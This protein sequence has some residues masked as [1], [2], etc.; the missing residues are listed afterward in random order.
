MRGLLS[1][2]FREDG[3]CAWAYRGFEIRGLRRFGV[4]CGRRAG[5]TG[6]VVFATEPSTARAAGRPAFTAGVACAPRHPAGLTPLPGSPPPHPPQVWPS[7]HRQHRGVAHRPLAPAGQDAAPA[8]GLLR[9]AAHGC[10]AA[11]ARFA[12][13][14]S[15]FCTT[16]LTSGWGGVDKTAWPSP[17]DR[18]PRR[19]PD[20]PP[21]TPLAT[22]LPLN[23]P[24]PHPLHSKA[25]QQPPTPPQTGRL[26]NRFTK[27][28][29]ALDTQ[30]SA[31]VNSA[32]T[33]LVGV[34][35]S[36]AAVAAVSPYVLVALVPLA[37]LY[38]RVQVG[39]RGGVWPANGPALT[40]RA[41]LAARAAPL[42]PRVC[43]FAFAVLTGLWGRYGGSGPPRPRLACT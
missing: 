24:K 43:R 30:M 15:C 40:A 23:H 17:I 27:D 36:V 28:T 38:Y 5:F 12:C 13:L 33:C 34:A 19:T 42:G 29:E 25:T 8:N 9:L 18:Q 2:G 32:L 4:D 7:G 14:F 6:L 3:L 16:G 20:E 39:R 26:V 21:T 10:V 31:A 37:A 1:A 35:A 11:L 41:A 22:P